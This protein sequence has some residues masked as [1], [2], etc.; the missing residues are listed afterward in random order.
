MGSHLAGPRH[1][2]LHGRNRGTWQKKGISAAERFNYLYS[3]QEPR[4]FAG[5]LGE[6][7]KL[8]L[9]LHLL[10]NACYRDNAQWNVFQLQ[11][12]LKD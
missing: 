4:E 7:G 2:A 10:F 3:D 8:T 9:E 1:R 5:L 12:L 6:L 11:R